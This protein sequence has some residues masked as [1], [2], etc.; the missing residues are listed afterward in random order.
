MSR[1]NAHTLILDHAESLYKSSVISL[2]D[3]NDIRQRVSIKETAVKNEQIEPLK[4]R[5]DVA[6]ILNVSLRQVDRL[7]EANFLRKRRI[8]KRSVRFTLGD[9]T[10]LA[11][12]RNTEEIG[13]QP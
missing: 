5:N 4:T 1:L 6:T 2:E 11:D 8:G 13:G 9:I 12:I 10:K 7:T 3:L